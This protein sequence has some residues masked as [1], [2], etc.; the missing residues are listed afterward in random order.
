MQNPKQK[1]IFGNQVQIPNKI[2]SQHEI[3]KHF[4]K[5]MAMISGA[6]KGAREYLRRIRTVLWNI[7]K[8]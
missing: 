3:A 4:G 8:N 5:S 7:V 2:K 1:N 6:S